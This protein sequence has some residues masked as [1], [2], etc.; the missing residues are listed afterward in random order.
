[1]TIF[2]W[3]GNLF[4]PQSTIDAHERL[5]VALRLRLLR[6]HERHRADKEPEPLEMYRED[7]R[8]VRDYYEAHAAPV[9]VYRVARDLLEELGDE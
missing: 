1:M 7:A 3:I 5:V 9:H 4:F 6:D 8:I 2:E